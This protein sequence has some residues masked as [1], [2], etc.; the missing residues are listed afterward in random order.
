MSGSRILLDTNIVIAW[1]AEEETVIHFIRRS[2]RIIIPCLPVYLPAGR[3][4]SRRD[5][6]QASIVMG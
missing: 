4:A 3:Q 2:G 6:R 5:G 1:F